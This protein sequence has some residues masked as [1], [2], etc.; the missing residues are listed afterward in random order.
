MSVD[1]SEVLKAINELTRTV[2][3]Y[4]A[5]FREFR[6]EQKA[7]VEALEK[8]ASNNRMWMKVQAICVLPVVGGIHQVA[9]HFGWLK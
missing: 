4:H 6:G 9:A 8:D 5:D 2:E 3:V 1:N 7:K